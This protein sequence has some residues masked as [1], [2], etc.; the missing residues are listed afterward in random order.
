MELVYIVLLLL[1]AVYIP[2]YIY[3][4]KSPR[5]K[6]LGLVPYGP[7][8]MVKTKWGF[9][10]ME[11]LAKYKRFWRV[12]GFVSKVISL[13]LMIAIVAIMALNVIS[14]PLA[15]GQKGIGIQYALAIPGLNPMLPLWY[16]IIGLIFAMAIHELAHGIQTR[17]NDMELES[18]GVLYGVVPLGAFVEPNQEA[19]EKA[20]RRE[21]MDLY[22]AGIAVNLVAA[23]AVFAL[24]F[25]A[26]GSGLTA[27]DGDCPAVVAVTPDSP[28]I[29]SGIPMGSII[30]SV[31]EVGGTKV[32]V[33]SEADFKSAV[34]HYGKYV[35][36]YRQKDGTHVSG[37]ITMGVFVNDIVP[38][39]PAQASGLDK[40][41]FI[42]AIDGV[43]F[44]TVEGFRDALAKYSPG[45]TVRI[46]RISGDVSNEM[47][48]TLSDRNGKAFLG[49]VMTTSGFA[50]TTPNKNLEKATNPF[51]GADG[52]MGFATSALLYISG[53]FKGYSPLPESTHW[54]YESNWM[55]DNV[56]W[57]MVSLLFWIFW[58]NL[59]LGLSNALPA[60]PFDGG[61]LFMGG[62]DFILEKF[63][64]EQAK[65]ERTV[66]TVC[67]FVTYLSL[68]I[69]L[70]VVVV[71]ML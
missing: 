12:F 16:G 33:N 68:M 27:T 22:S 35:L 62:V 6:E 51:A 21:R 71:I 65:R 53:P 36:E 64:V 46:T 20:G 25:V 44:G 39:S 49:V 1:L 5:M 43:E 4:K 18:S 67:S 32:P 41:N 28:G 14:L 66:N 8:I 11:R 56:F 23:I 17:A 3:V 40:G 57:V 48:V 10:T 54:W 29:H 50:F 60:V 26:L 34:G 58:L 9:R 70:M 42:M 59:V 15:M 30:V 61:F 31:T 45:D 52:V 69:L 63:G 2:I 24:L 19:V 37:E 13:I 38:D 47:D 55:P 7:L